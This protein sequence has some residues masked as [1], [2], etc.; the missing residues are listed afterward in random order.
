MIK[1]YIFAYRQ[2]PE[3]GEEVVAEQPYQHCSG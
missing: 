3:T 1:L 2:M